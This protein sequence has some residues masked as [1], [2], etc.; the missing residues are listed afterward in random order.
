MPQ[1]S[2]AHHVTTIQ[3][4]VCFK[5]DNAVTYCIQPNTTW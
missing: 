5:S 3:Y 4:S 1:I 2:T